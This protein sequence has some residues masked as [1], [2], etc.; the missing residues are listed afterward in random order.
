M[1]GVY[2]E[3]IVLLYVILGGIGTAFVYDLIRVKRR[4]LSNQNIAAW[5][6]DLLFWIFAAIVMFLCIYAGND[7]AP[8]F[9]S[10]SGFFCG[11]LIYMLMLSKIIR[12]FL[13]K[14][15]LIVAH[16]IK[17]IYLILSW[18]IKRLIKGILLIRQF[19]MRRSSSSE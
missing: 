16:I 11:I 17:R 1:K 10:V 3:I 13:E 7:G 9:Y 8:R 15:L 5:I 12:K 2:G 6:E 14:A 18:P 19:Y 4:V